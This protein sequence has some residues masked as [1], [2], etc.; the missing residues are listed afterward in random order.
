M[1]NKSM[2]K[3]IQWGLQVCLIVLLAACSDSGNNGKSDSEKSENESVVFAGSL[4]QNAEKEAKADKAEQ[5]VVAEA[6]SNN[7][8][9]QTTDIEKQAA[10]MA[11]KNAALKAKLKGKYKDPL[12]G[13]G[14]C[15]SMAAKPCLYSKACMWERDDKRLYSC[16]D[17]VNDCE[18]GFAQEGDQVKSSCTDKPGC[19]YKSASCF[20]PPGVTCVCGG[21][22][23]AACLVS[24]G[25]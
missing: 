23:P 19:E 20:C 13:K 9:T 21:G 18:N 1:L 10:A 2:K 15:A 24:E 7:S 12:Q 6:D 16:R 17:A 5:H 11:A 4:E 3:S 22:T 8:Q 14:S 25:S